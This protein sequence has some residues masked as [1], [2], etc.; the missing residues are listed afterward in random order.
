MGPS[1]P[2]GPPGAAGPPG[3]PGSGI[4]FISEPFQEKAPDPFRGGHYRADDPNMMRD[5]DMEVDTTL[6]TLTQKVEIIRSPDGTQK[7]PVR[8]CRDLKMAH[9]EWKS[10]MFWVDPN[11]GSPLDAIKVHCNMETGETCVYPSESSI[12]MKNWYLSKNIRE[13][14]HVWFSESMTGGFQFQYG[15]NGA[16]P[17]D[18]NIQMTFMRLMS[19]QASQNM[20]YHCKNSIA[21]MD[22]AT[23]NLKKALLL[24]GTN[25]VEIRAEGNSRFTYSVSEDG[26][27]SHTGSWGKTVIDYKTSKTSRLPIIDIAPMDVGAPDQ[28]FGVEVG[29]VCFL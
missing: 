3:P 13:K 16:D 23:G 8:M 9:P 25:D 24:Q 21:Y 26:C 12:P 7:S 18:V 20:T 6:K 15:S 29:P 28:E 17:E 1:G 2:P 11:Q 27:T 14:K 5:R 4:N 22:S 10:D 19:N